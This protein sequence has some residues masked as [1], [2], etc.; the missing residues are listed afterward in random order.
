MTARHGERWS[1]AQAFPQGTVCPW[2]GDRAGCGGCFSFENQ[3]LLPSLVCNNG[4]MSVPLPDGHRGTRAPEPG[5]V[6]NWILYFHSIMI[7]L[8]FNGLMWPV[9]TCYIY[10]WNVP[11]RPTCQR[12][13]PQPWALL[14][15]RG[16][17]KGW[18]QWLL[19]PWRV[20]RKRPACLFPCV[21][22]LERSS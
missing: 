11:K 1:R 22:S 4:S 3:I 18:T 21:C 6:G 12:L 16:D 20:P 7:N 17:W 13:G 19:W 10:N 8:L 2:L 14:G 9:A 15:G 5:E